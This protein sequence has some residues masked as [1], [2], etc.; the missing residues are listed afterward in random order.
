[1]GCCKSTVVL[2]PLPNK[3]ERKGHLQPLK[4]NDA[5]RMWD[6]NIY[7]SNGM[8]RN[9]ESYVKLCTTSEDV[10]VTTSCF[11]VWHRSG[12]VNGFGKVI[13]ALRTYE[14]RERGSGSNYNRKTAV[15]FFDDNMNLAAGGSESTPGICNLR[16]V[17][18]SEYVDFSVGQNGFSR[19][20][21]FDQTIVHHS[22]EYRNILVQASILDA[23]SHKDYFTKIILK[24]A[25]NYEKVLAFIDVNATILLED[26]MEEKGASEVVLTTLFT[27]AQAQAKEEV[28]FRFLDF[29]PVMIKKSISLK[30]LM[31]KVCKG[32][33]Q[34]MVG[35]WKAE[36]C[37]QFFRGVCAIADIIWEPTS[38]SLNIDEFWVM[39]KKYK[40]CA[41]TCPTVA[42]IPMS[43]FECFDYLRARD[44]S[45]VINSFGF[46][47]RKILYNTVI[48]DRRS[49]HVTVNYDLWTER[50]T[51][52]FLR[53][54]KPNIPEDHDTE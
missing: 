31:Q 38:A 6:M 46:D 16:D 11:A 18:T 44:H 50:D 27:K 15:F 21:L 33:K 1:M 20:D 28:E 10:V 49:L 32:D 29:A 47:S 36:V 43:W 4:C 34:F 51:Q 26:T 23:I 30:K 2:E 41:E 13:P 7:H 42:G 5:L 39:Y 35:F 8:S 12:M 14:Q 17:G 52:E 53:T 54:Y 25:R 45:I 24:Y 3:L 37:D 40:L 9:L 22:S 19:E 48:D